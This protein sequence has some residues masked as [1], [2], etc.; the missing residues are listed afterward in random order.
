MKCCFIIF[1]KLVVEYCIS[2]LYLFYFT[3]LRAGAK[4]NGHL[5]NLETHTFSLGF[6]FTSLTI[7]V[8]RS[9]GEAVLGPNS[10]V[11][12]QPLIDLCPLDR[13]WSGGTVGKQG[14][15]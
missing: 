10:S 15:T 11:A 8:F 3:A 5:L 1:T 13:L 12:G 9:D 4:K 7:I 6:K 2:Y 14:W